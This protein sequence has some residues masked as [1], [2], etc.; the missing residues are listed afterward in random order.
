MIPPPSAFYRVP[1]VEVVPLPFSTAVNIRRTCA[2]PRDVYRTARKIYGQWSYFAVTSHGAV[3]GPYRA[4]H[5]ETDAGIVAGLLMALNR[6]D[7]VRHLALV[8][9]APMAPRSTVGALAARTR[10]L[11]GFAPSRLRSQRPVLSALG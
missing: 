6:M 1:P 3:L 10:M 9:E 8:E 11:C 2:L 7:P 4:R 5:D